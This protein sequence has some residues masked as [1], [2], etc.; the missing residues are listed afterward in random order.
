M[1]KDL[2]IILIDKHKNA[3]ID[4]V[5]M[6]NWTWLRVIISSI[7]DREWDKYNDAADEIMRK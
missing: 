3:L 2:A 6:L 7:P 5:E 4:P 1:D